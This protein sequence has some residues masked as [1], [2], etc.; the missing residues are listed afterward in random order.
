MRE[1]EK[2]RKKEEGNTILMM[3]RHSN[4]FLVGMWMVN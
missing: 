1:G 3:S 4:G 2:K